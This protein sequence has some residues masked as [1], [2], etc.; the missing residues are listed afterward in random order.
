ML[1]GF[2]ASLGV[3]LVYLVFRRALARGVDCTLAQL[4]VEKLL[5]PSQEEKDAMEADASPTGEARPR[6]R[7]R[8]KKRCGED[9][10][11]RSPLM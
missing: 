6:G 10:E 5:S 8:R 9:A 11:V 7:K 1:Y 3:L 2:A 4:A